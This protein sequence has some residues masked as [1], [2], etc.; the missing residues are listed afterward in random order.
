MRRRQPSTFNL[1][2][3]SFSL[4]SLTLFPPS[5]PSSP[6]LNFSKQESAKVLEAQNLIKRLNEVRNSGQFPGLPLL[7][8]SGS[9]NMRKRSSRNKGGA[10]RGGGGRGAL[11]GEEEEGELSKERKRKGSSRRRGGGRRALE[12]KQKALSEVKLWTKKSLEGKKNSRQKKELSL[13]P[14]SDA[15][16]VVSLPTPSSL[17]PLLLPPSPYKLP[18]PN[19]PPP[20]NTTSSPRSRPSAPSPVT[21]STPRWSARNPASCPSCWPRNSSRSASTTWRRPTTRPGAGPTAPSA[22]S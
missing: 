21:A 12:G 3:F 1:D 2:T 10:G 17:S 19:T 11:E 13:L 18:P 15:L 7:R 22:R 14:F 16:I 6:A 8:L 5:H 4:S 9:K 20:R